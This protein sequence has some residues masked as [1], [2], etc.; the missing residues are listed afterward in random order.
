MPVAWVILN[1]GMVYECSF[2]RVVACFSVLWQ[3]VRTAVSDLFI[4]LQTIPVTICAKVVV[5]G[6]VAVLEGVLWYCVWTC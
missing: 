3:R 4:F 5:Q 2:G 1:S 6:V